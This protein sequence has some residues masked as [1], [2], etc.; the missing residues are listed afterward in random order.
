MFSEQAAF[1]TAHADMSDRRTGDPVL[2]PGAYETPKAGIHAVL[3][4]LAATCG[5]YNFVAWT[6]RRETHL[7]VNAVLYA[8]LW[9]WETYQTHHHLAQKNKTGTKESP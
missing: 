5:V 4:G 6:K 3:G 1:H 2:Q 9:A 8:A 7:A